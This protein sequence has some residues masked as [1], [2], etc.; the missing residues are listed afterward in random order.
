MSWNKNKHVAPSLD[1]NFTTVSDKCTAVTKKKKKKLSHSK[2]WN[3]KLFAFN[4]ISRG[5]NYQWIRS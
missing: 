4:N 1:I 3:K 2:I 5:N